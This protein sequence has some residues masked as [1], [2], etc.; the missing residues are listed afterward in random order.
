MTEAQ[1]SDQ[2]IAL[3]EKAK[4]GANHLLAVVEISNGGMSLSLGIHKIS[5]IEMAF[6]IN[7]MVSEDPNVLVVFKTLQEKGAFDKKTRTVEQ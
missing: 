3:L 2:N 6:V 7:A 1:L 5:A 4:S